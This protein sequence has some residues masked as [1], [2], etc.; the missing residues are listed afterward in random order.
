MKGQRS[1]TSFTRGMLAEILTLVIEI[2]HHLNFSQEPFGQ[3]F[4]NHKATE[5]LGLCE[6]EEGSTPKAR[7]KPLENL[8]DNSS[9]SE[10][11]ATNTIPRK[12]A[13]QKHYKT[14]EHVPFEEHVEQ[15]PRSKTSQLS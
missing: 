9:P 14:V 15:T 4:G 13:S 6:K 11:N 7:K 1:T 8:I 5:K 10:K 12:K 3:R 2:S